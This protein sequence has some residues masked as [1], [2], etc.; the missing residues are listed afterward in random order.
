MDT[1]DQPPKKRG[2]K[3][4]SIINNAKLDT[5]KENKVKKNMIIRIKLNEKD[6]LLNILP[7]YSENNLNE[8]KNNK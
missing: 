4:N 1:K 2:R 5:S 3:P 6:E 7:G 8:Y